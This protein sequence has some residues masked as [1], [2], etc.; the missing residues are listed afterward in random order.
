MIDSLIQMRILS[1]FAEVPALRVA[2]PYPFAIDPSGTRVLSLKTGEFL[3]VARI[4]SLF[5]D[6]GY[7]TPAVTRAQLVASAFGI[8]NEGDGERLFFK[9]GDNTNCAVENLTF[10]RN[11][12]QWAPKASNRGMK[13]PRARPCKTPLG[14]FASVLAASDAHKVDRTTILHRIRVGKGGYEWL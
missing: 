10:N 2:Y 9:D 5:S 7:K 11:A 3:P 1:A 14:E 6:P 8:S 4:Y 12:E 13:H